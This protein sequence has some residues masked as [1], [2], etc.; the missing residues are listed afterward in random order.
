MSKCVK[1]DI[2]DVCSLVKMYRLSFGVSEY[3]SE[4][5]F[6]LIYITIFGDLVMRSHIIVLDIFCQLLMIIASAHGFTSSRVNM[7]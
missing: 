5:Q 4:H 1:H 7:K 2:C 3:K 6:D